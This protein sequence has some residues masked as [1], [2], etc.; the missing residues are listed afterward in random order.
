M[1]GPQMGI[2]K[3]QVADLEIIAA[4]RLLFGGSDAVPVY[5]LA[6]SAREITTTL[7]EKRG[8][9]SFFDDARELLPNMSKKE[10]YRE[11]HRHAGYFKHANNDPDGVLV[12]FAHSEAD[13][14]LFVASYD[15]ALLCGG[16]SIE[17][18]VFEGWFLTLYGSPTEIP[19][20]LDEMFPN[21]RARPRFDQVAL[22]GSVL[23]W[24]REVP[25]FKMSYSLELRPASFT[26]SS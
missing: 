20:G 23:K 5:V 19:R 1:G 9:R 26:S 13:M 14:V 7:C 10:M 16:K 17:A 18:Q 21:L 3:L 24:A 25:D 12:D 22:G 15:F 6:A 4:V 8:I 11:A 2:T